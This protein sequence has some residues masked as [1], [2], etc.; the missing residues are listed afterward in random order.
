[1]ATKPAFKGLFHVVYFDCHSAHLLTPALRAMLHERGRVVM[2]TAKYLVDLTPEQRKAFNE[3]LAERA[4]A[5]GLKPVTVE[6]DKADALV[7]EM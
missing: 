3:K 1:M 2:E 7:F 4:A 5:A 6:P